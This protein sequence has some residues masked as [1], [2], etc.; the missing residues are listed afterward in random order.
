MGYPALDLPPITTRLEAG[1]VA[2]RY[3]AHG[4][5]RGWGLE[6]GTLAD[7]IAAHPLYNEALEVARG[8]SVMREHRLMNLFLIITCYLNLLPH[9]NIA[10]FGSYR[11]GSAL[12]MAHLLRR[13]YP[14]A[15]LFAFDTFEGMPKVNDA[16]DLHEAGDFSDSD[17]SGLLQARLGSS[18]PQLH[19]VQGLVQETFA[20]SKARALQFGLAHFDMDIYEPTVFA[21]EQMWPLMCK[22]GYYVYD[23]AT[24]SS[25]IGAM[26]AVEDLIRLRGLHS[27]QAYPHFVFRVGLN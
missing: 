25:C 9:Q 2:G 5:A 14:R 19:I 10:E 13:L 24:V 7:Q 17:L 22:G 6:F 21:Q 18:L 20:A 27:E 26:Q 4:Y 1:V 16:A 12:F 11:G 8:R 15:R 3:P 23:D